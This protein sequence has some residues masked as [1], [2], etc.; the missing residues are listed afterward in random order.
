VASIPLLRRNRRRFGFDDPF[1]S[2]TDMNQDQR[3]TLDKDITAD[4]SVQPS[5][6]CPLLGVKG[7][8]ASQVCF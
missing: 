6:E 1:M 5:A 2:V 4:R 3:L 8:L 7:T